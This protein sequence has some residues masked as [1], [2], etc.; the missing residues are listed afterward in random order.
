MHTEKIL[1]FNL[2]LLVHNSEC[3]AKAHELIVNFGYKLILEQQ[4]MGAAISCCINN[5]T[6]Q[7]REEQPLLRLSVLIDVQTYSRI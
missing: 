5:G 6:F 2:C 7:I 1:Y 4:D 3:N